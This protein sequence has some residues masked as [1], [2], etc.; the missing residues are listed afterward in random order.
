MRG[1][2]GNARL[3]TCR[4]RDVGAGG[5][6]CLV[7]LADELGPFDELLRGPEGIAQIRAPSLELGRETTIQHDAGPGIEQFCKG[8]RVRNHSV[9]NK[10]GLS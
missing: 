3:I 4:H 1:K 10:Q 2:A 7:Y 6:V 9:E 5:E 8:A